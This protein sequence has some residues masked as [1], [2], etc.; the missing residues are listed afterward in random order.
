[1]SHVPH[2]SARVSSA[3]AGR[4]D[5]A[6]H[7]GGEHIQPLVCAVGPGRG[8]ALQRPGETHLRS[9]QRPTISTWTHLWTTVRQ[10]QRYKQL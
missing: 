6:L 7:P 9:T 3:E 2:A 1:M 4:P 10:R 5:A 8:H